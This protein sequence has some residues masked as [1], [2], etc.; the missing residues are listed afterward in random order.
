MIP[1]A[2]VGAVFAALPRLQGAAIHIHRYARLRRH[3]PNLYSGP[4]PGREVHAATDIPR[5]VIVLDSGL[6]GRELRRILIHEV[7]H[8]AWVR[9]GNRRRGGWECLLANEIHAHARGELGWSAQF[10]KDE[11]TP[12]DVRGRSRRWRGYLCEAFCDTA[13]CRW[14]GIAQ[15]EEFTLSGRWR[16][17]RFAWLDDAVADRPIPI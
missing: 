11:L 3:G 10:R 2:V 17:R 1:L 13:A 12:E 4:G 9:L 8:F 7:F 6:R 14:S 16:S 15:H 5:R